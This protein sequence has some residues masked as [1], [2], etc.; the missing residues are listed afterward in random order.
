MIYALGVDASRKGT[1]E[2]LPACVV[3]KITFPLER[4]QAS[5]TQ[6]QLIEHPGNLAL[7]LLHKS[8]EAGW[9]S[10]SGECARIDS[11]HRICGMLPLT[12]IDAKGIPISK[13]DRH[14]I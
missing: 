1:S 10:V 6:V 14:V 5:S 12:E 13:N 4:I 11:R 8:L 7:N 2:I 3:T 9:S